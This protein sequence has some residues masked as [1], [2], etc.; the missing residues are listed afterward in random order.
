[1][2]SNSTLNLSA[3]NTKV[4]SAIIISYEIE[5]SEY[6]KYYVQIENYHKQ[7]EYATAYPVFSFGYNT[8]SYKVGNRVLCL[9]RNNDHQKVFIIGQI[10]DPNIIKKVSPPQPGRLQLIT[11]GN[12]KSGMSQLGESDNMSLFSG[13]STL[14]FDSTKFNFSISTKN[15]LRFSENHFDLRFNDGADGLI[16]KNSRATLN[17]ANGFYIN[18]D[19]GP[20]YI[21]ASNFSF[22]EDNA[23][24]PNFFISK[25]LIRLIGV[26]SV[27]TFS[28]YKFSGGSKVK[29]KSDTVEWNILTGNYVIGLGSGDFKVQTTSTT[30]KISLK[31][32][33]LTPVASLTLGTNL[34]GSTEF[35]VLIGTSINGD[36]LTLGGGSFK[37]SAGSTPTTHSTFQVTDSKVNM[38]AKAGVTSSEINLSALQIKL[39]PPSKASGGKIILDGEVE[40]TGSLIVKDKVYS[41]DEIFA[42]AIIPE[43]GSPQTSSAVALSTHTHPT[44]VPGP[45]SPPKPGS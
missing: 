37:I 7:G 25:G 27:N 26:E 9:I 14:Q 45:V 43:S 38:I 20:I 30:S 36:E 15:Y 5:E 12:V 3:F 28:S 40:I 42:K 17:S 34:S 6:S 10:Y 23:D 1:M 22:T 33:P 16:F 31:I 2:I 24:K 19:D 18:A 44:A 32:G 39:I 11:D 8:S 21:K 4:E 41:S 35:N 29:G 13:S